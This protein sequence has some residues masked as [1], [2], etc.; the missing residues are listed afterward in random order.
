MA[1]VEQTEL[2]DVSDLDVIVDSDAHVAEGITDF[3]P[4]M[5][6]EH[7]GLKRIVDQAA[8]PLH[9]IYSVSHAMP[10]FQHSERQRELYADSQPGHLEAKQEELD[11]FDLDYGILNPTV[12]LS[13]TSV[14]NTRLA[15]ALARAYN[16][17]MLDTFLDEDARM[18]SPILVAPQK[19]DRAAEEID[20]LADEPGIV[21]IQIPFTGLI[22]PAGHRQ[23][24]PIYQAAADHDLPVFYHSGSGTTHEVFPHQRKWAETY[25][26][27]H[28][29]VHPFSHMWNFTN[30]IFTGLPERFPGVDFV[31]QEAGIAWIPYWV[32]RLDD[33]YLSLADEVPMLNQLPSAYVDECFYFSTQPLGHTAKNPD[34]LAWAIEMAG[35]GN[36]MYASDLPHPDFD[37]PNEL[38][39]RIN[40]HFDAET[41]RNI[42]GET[43]ID[44]FDL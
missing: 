29:M 36:I 27:D 1:Q 34:H 37:P 43:A 9:D 38:F 19:P 33:H 7:T 8:H 26:E 4:Y 11:E 31:L 35:P 2:T 6:E 25:A 17:W 44:V 15:V 10:P 16:S 20:R 42:L 22:P 14:N 23:Y 18:K 39:D 30:M 3:L 21:G 32:W 28:A 5:A 41:V 40:T 24:D 13:L 12:N